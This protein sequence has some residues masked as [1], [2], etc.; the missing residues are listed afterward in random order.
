MTSCDPCYNIVTV[1]NRSQIYG[2]GLRNSASI[3]TL[4]AWFLFESGRCRL[5]EWFRSAIKI[6]KFNLCS[7]VS[8]P[9]TTWHHILLASLFALWKLET[10]LCL[11]G[12]KLFHFFSVREP[13][14][15]GLGVS[16]THTHTH[17]MS[18][19]T[20]KVNCGNCGLI[21]KVISIM[22]TIDDIT[23]YI[24]KQFYSVEA[25]PRLVAISF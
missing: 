2:Q 25:S 12:R 23:N 16:H 15:H 10:P 18:F 1:I 21:G 20:S 5:C 22:C 14:T 6:S 11:R 24:V 9:P 13:V 4:L 17:H 3:L 8:I 7:H 19:I